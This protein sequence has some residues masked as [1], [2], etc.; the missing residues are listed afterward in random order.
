ML[1]NGLIKRIQDGVTHMSGVLGDG[2]KAVLNRNCPQVLSYGLSD[3]AA[4]ELFEFLPWQLKAPKG[5]MQAN[6]CKVFNDTALDYV[7][8]SIS[9]GSLKPAWVQ[10]VFKGD[11]P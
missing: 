4:L 2:W 9:E 5:S 8:C 11:V 3:M 1:I 7:N 6:N 10:V